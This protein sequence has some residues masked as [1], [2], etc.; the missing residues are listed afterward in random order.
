M[1]AIPVGNFIYI[2]GPGE[3]TYNDI[4]TDIGD[5]SWFEDK[6]GGIYE[7]KANHSL[8]VREDGV[9]VTGDENDFSKF[10]RLDFA[11]TSNN[12]ILFYIR[13]GGHLKMFGN[14][15]M[16]F[17]AIAPNY[18]FTDFVS[19]SGTMTARGNVTY[20]PSWLG[21]RSPSF[22]S[23]NA[24]SFSILDIQD[25]D[26]DVRTPSKGFGST[27]MKFGIDANCNMHFLR[28]KF[29]GNS[30]YVNPGDGIGC[31]ELLPLA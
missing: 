22:D 20:R 12:S 11:G 2:I 1:P 30:E 23:S 25:M 13:E 28:C 6:G 3:T 15:H 4:V 26:F 29:D 18:Y 24:S 10:E 14:V 5:P 17:A 16:D 9:L 27:T 31:R 8:D 7:I 21:L 19:L